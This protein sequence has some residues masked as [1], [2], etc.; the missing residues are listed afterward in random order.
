MLNFKFFINIV[1]KFY[2]DLPKKKS[3]LIFD[4]I[5]KKIISSFVKNKNIYFIKVR[6]NSYNFYALI[7]AAIF[8]YRSNYKIEYLNFFFLI[9]NSNILL[10]TSFKRFIIYQIKNFYPKRKILVIQNGSFGKKFPD[11]IK[12]SSYKNFKCDYFFC[13]SKAEIVFLKDLI[14]T[15]FKILGSFRSNYYPITK[16][17]TKS[18]I[19]YISQY[20][21]DLFGDK[22]F[23]DLYYSEKKLLPV[24]LNFCKKINKRLEILP[25]ENDHKKEHV[26]FKKILKSNQFFLHKRNIK[27][28]YKI[29]DISRLCVG[30]DSS[31][32]F[33]SIS[34]GSK[35][36]IFNF[37]IS[38]NR[39]ITSITKNYYKYS[40]GKF[41]L[42]YFDK[43]KLNKI[44][45]HIYN[46][47]EKKWKSNNFNK[48]IML[49]YI[50]N[51]EKIDNI[52]N[53]LI[54]ND[55]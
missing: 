51:N 25:G 27:N 52:L 42:K 28:S 6:N 8:C 35:V 46:M 49:P 41:W 38:H 23:R 11:T 45:E 24:L 34:R 19:V 29:C 22:N 47:N 21:K 43:H 17:K 2:F 18:S 12:N 30:I 10:T 33:E 16:L 9:S 44:F 3:I 40:E 36:A 15:N 31:L 39:N 54:N 26:H 37:D 1:P 13:F 53:N 20:R 14:I 48:V 7:Y 32:I 5:E 50:R 4:D 55:E